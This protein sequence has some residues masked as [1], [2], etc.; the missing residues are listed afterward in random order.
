[1]YISSQH[2]FVTLR[3]LT[4]TGLLQL[5]SL[6]VAY[7]QLKERNGIPI[8]CLPRSY[9]FDICSCR[10]PFFPLLSAPR[11]STRIFILANKTSDTTS[12]FL[13]FKRQSHLLSFRFVHIF[14]FLGRIA[15]LLGNAPFLHDIFWPNFFNGLLFISNVR[16][17]DLR[18]NIVRNVLNGYLLCVVHN[19]GRLQATL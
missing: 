15:K 8:D 11:F 3:I 13:S 14:S 19:H 4:Y 2:I 1:M 9:L 12:S 10:F 5:L 17:C 6:R 18:Y 7:I 16:H